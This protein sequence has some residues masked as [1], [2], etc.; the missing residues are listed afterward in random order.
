[1]VDLVEKRLL[2]TRRDPRGLTL[3]VTNRRDDGLPV[4]DIDHESVTEHF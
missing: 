2:E 3:L 1:L 4:T